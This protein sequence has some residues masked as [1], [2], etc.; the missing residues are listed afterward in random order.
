MAASSC[1]KCGKRMERGWVLDHTYGSRGVSTWI[2]GAPE[3]SV[4][5]GVRLGGRTAREIATYRC[6][7]CGYLENY[8][9]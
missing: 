3:K 6:T 2:S 8:A 5:V 4:W 1:A 9:E 7:G